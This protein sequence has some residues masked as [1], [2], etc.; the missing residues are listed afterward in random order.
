MD[1]FVQDQERRFGAEARY[2]QRENSRAPF[3]EIPLIRHDR[4]YLLKEI[5]L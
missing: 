2:G 1:F 4:K 3:F 5:N